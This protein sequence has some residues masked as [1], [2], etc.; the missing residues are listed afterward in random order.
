MAKTI[1]Y[2]DGPKAIEVSTISCIVYEH[3]FNADLIADVMGTQR[4]SEY[5][6]EMGEVVEMPVS[7]DGGEYVFDYHDFNWVKCLKALWAC[8]KAADPSVQPFDAW[9][10][11]L[12]DIDM[13][14]VVA[15]LR[16][17]VEARLFRHGATAS[18]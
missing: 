14:E 1:D 16:R 15:F 17:E 2:G 11:S 4:L 3:E 12:P 9:S 7:K 8:L 5:S 18:E 13:W 6:L 10:S